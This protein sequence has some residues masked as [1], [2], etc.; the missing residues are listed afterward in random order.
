M[1]YILT[2]ENPWRPFED[3]ILRKFKI[4][5]SQKMFGFIT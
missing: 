4:K 5:E 3:L 1:D 2:S